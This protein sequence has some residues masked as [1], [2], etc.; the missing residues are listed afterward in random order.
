M[1][2]LLCVILTLSILC[3]AG[4]GDGVKVGSFSSLYFNSDEFQEAVNELL[5]YFKSFEG[6]TLT[7]INY[8][9]DD[10]VRAEAE[11]RGLPNELVMVME[12]TF[13]TDG[14]N[15]ENGLEPNFTYENYRWI[16]TRDFVGGPWSHADH[17][18]G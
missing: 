13:T 8:A 7:E 16:F 15:H 14:E 4:C 18:Y 2:K 1:K 9:G 10:A 17:G 6:C 3:L 5:T 11:A 12:S